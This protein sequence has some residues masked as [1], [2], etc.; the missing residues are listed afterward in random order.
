MPHYSF[1]CAACA[2]EY[3]VRCNFDETATAACPDCGVTEKR[4]LYQPIGISVKEQACNQQQA[5]P[6]ASG[7]GCCPNSH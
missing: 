7:G 1:A 6:L 2:M 5:C 4:R 3:D